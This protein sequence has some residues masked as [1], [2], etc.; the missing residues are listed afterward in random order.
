MATVL[1]PGR[2]SPTRQVPASIIRPEYVGKK[3]PKLGE[4]DVPDAE[5]IALMRVA[6]KLAARALDEN[7]QTYN[8]PKKTKTYLTSSN[9]FAN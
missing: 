3:R 7:V 1:H 9:N 6:G 5:T 8:N 4:P 2:L